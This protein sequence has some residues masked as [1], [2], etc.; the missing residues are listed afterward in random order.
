MEKAVALV[1]ATNS[2]IQNPDKVGNMWKVVS[3]RLRGAKTELSEMGEETEGMVESTSKLR[4]LVKGITGFDIMEDENTFKD[5]Y[6]IVLG[7]GKAWDDVNDIDRAALLEALAGKQQSNSLAAALSNTE[8]LEKSYKE[9]MQSAGSAMR[10]QEKYQE[11]IQY[12]IDR[13]KASLEELSNTTINSESL[14]DFIDFGNGVIQVLNQM[15]E[16]FGL[17]PGVVAAATAF[18]GRGKLEQQFCPVWG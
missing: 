13:A 17:M 3:A 10:E 5:I 12:S 9:A 2:V 18:F 4:D 6:E 8:I 7:I 11:S 1:T 15:I 16:K 14:K